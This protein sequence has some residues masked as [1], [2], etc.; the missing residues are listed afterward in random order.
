LSRGTHRAAQITDHQLSAAIDRDK[1][2]LTVV[3]QVRNP[4][5]GNARQCHAQCLKCEHRGM[6][7]DLA[8]VDIIPQTLRAKLYLFDSVYQ[9]DGR[10]DSNRSRKY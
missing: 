9:L 2:I 5:V 3:V 7:S 10:N 6:N 4:T 1:Q 8:L